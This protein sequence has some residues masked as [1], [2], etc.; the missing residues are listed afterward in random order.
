MHIKCGLSISNFF[1]YWCVLLLK[2]SIARK[3]TV[4]VAKLVF[5][6]I[7]YTVWWEYSCGFSYKRFYSYCSQF[8]I[9]FKKPRKCKITITPGI[10]FS[11]I[12]LL[13]SPKTIHSWNGSCCE[14]WQWRNYI[15]AEVK[16]QGKL[17]RDHTLGNEWMPTSFRI[18][19]NG[20]CWHQRKLRAESNQA[21]VVKY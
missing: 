3:T 8:C 15:W 2:T 13:K 14:T 20:C 12:G 7:D 9:L 17:C 1:S 18:F 11:E 16:P 4:F 21:G 6:W 10:L 19:V 5:W